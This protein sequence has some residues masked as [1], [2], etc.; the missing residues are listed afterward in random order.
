MSSGRFQKRNS[1]KTPRFPRSKC[2]Q[3][4]S[5]NLSFPVRPG[6]RRRCSSSTSMSLGRSGTCQHRKGCTKLLLG[7]LRPSPLC[8]KCT[9]PQVYR[10]QPCTRRRCKRWLQ[11]KWIHSPPRSSNTNSKL[12]LSRCSVHKGRNWWHQKSQSTFLQNSPRTECHRWYPY[13]YQHCNLCKRSCLHR[14]LCQRHMKHNLW[15]QRRPQ[16]SLR[17]SSCMR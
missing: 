11:P 8:M 5:S 12:R 13:R 4:S 2:P 3:C 9:G 16:K 15:P 10:S 1:R 6:T 14:K 7:R 17:G